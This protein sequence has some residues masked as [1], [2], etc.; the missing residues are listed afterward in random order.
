VGDRRRN[1]TLA[2]RWDVLCALALTLPASLQASGVTLDI[3]QVEARFGYSVPFGPAATF[4]TPAG[5]IIT[6]TG[7]DPDPIALPHAF[8]VGTIS[9]LG[10]FSLSPAAA[11]ERLFIEATAPLVFQVRLTFSSPLGIRTGQTQTYFL[12]TS[13]V[14]ENG[15]AFVNAAADYGCLPACQPYPGPWDH[16]PRTLYYGDPDGYGG[17]YV[18]LRLRTAVTFS[19]P[20]PAGASYVEPLELIF[21]SEHVPEPS[22]CGLMAIALGSLIAARR[23]SA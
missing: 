18:H 12:S 17:G 21:E 5:A 4:T 19:S 13:V 22:T 1:V 2:S 20:P 16:N 9:S 7:V 3:A 10:A 23:M 14:T 11:D 8:T 15:S 6:F